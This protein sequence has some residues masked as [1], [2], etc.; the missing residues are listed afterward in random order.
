M[1]C[2][3]RCYQLQTIQSSEG[4][5]CLF[6]YEE[7]RAERDAT[8][9]GGSNVTGPPSVHVL[10]AFRCI[11]E[12]CRS[13]RRDAFLHTSLTERNLDILSTP[14]ATIVTVIGSIE[15]FR[16]GTRHVRSGGLVRNCSAC[17]LQGRRGYILIAR[18]ASSERSRVVCYGRNSCSRLV[19]ARV[20]EAE[21]RKIAEFA[22]NGH[23]QAMTEDKDHRIVA[24]AVGDHF[25]SAREICEH[26]GLDA[27]DA[28]YRRR[29]RIAG[30]IGGMAALKPLLA[31]SNKKARLRVVSEHASR[32][33]DVW[34][35]LDFSGKTTFTTRQDQLVRAKDPAYVQRVMHNGRTRVNVWGAV[36]KCGLGSLHR[37]EARLTYTRDDVHTILI[38]FF[39]SGLFSDHNFLFQH[40]LAPVHTARMVKDHLQQYGI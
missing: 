21:R 29:L 20:S 5:M 22:Q 26:L 36:S 40:D 33:A 32:E 6:V 8:R 17:A 30:L 15:W 35:W 27:A 25:L 28:T 11:R 3:G 9:R 7:R 13:T 24:A 10:G 14:L 31:A 12:S 19:M 18:I 4:V 39:H 38:P 23:S 34:G 37:I 1:N 2:N 16:H